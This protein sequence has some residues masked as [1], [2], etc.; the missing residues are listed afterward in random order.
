LG[1]EPALEGLLEPLHLAA[2][3][4]VV[5]TGVLVGDPE[6][7]QGGLELVAA[8]SPAREPGGVHQGVVGQHG[9]GIAVLACGFGE[10]VRHGGAGDWLVGG[11]RQGVAGVVIQP[12]EDLAVGPVGQVPVGEVR[13]PALI[14]DGGLESDVG[15]TRP[16]LG[17]RCDQARGQQSTPD[18]RHRHR[19]LVTV[20]QVP[21]DG[22][23]AG[24]ETGGR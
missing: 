9:G 12:G 8:T 15:R 11:D 4:G 16:L 20:G 18:R 3:G 2:G 6:A 13:L 7:R 1:G 21:G 10:G 17:L 5:G 19:Q 24:V 22:L 14:R 23:G